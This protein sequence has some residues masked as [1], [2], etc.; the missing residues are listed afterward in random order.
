M[1]DERHRTGRPTTPSALGPRTVWG[2]LCAAVALAGAP[3]VALAQG[4]GAQTCAVT[5]STVVFPDYDVFAASDTTTAGAV[6]F[7]CSKAQPTAVSIELTGGSL[8]NGSRSMSGTGLADRLSYNLFRDAAFTQVWGDGTSGTS[9]YSVNNRTTAEVSV[10]IY[11]RIPK[12]QD[13][14]V[15]SYTDTITATLNY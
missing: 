4:G 13:V 5:T 12:N 11:A 1:S 10:P 15:G 6:R 7:Q 2:L 14:S 8:L 3:P 9:L